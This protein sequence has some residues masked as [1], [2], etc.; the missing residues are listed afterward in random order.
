MSRPSDPP[1]TPGCT[2]FERSCLQNMYLFFNL[3]VMMVPST[4][5]VANA[6]VA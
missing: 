3:T 5:A 1:Y 2:F 6:S 4:L